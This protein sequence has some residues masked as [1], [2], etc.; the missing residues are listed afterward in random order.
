MTTQCYV[1]PLR[2]V[3]R[4]APTSHPHTTPLCSAPE[5]SILF[6]PPSLSFASSLPCS[7]SLRQ[8]V[9]PHNE[10]G[11]TS[12]SSSRQRHSGDT[13]TAAARRDSPSAGHHLPLHSP[14]SW[15]DNT[16]PCAFSLR[17]SLIL[18]H[19]LSSLNSSIGFDSL[20]LLLSRSL[21]SSD[22]GDHH[23]EAT[24]ATAE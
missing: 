1:L 10:V 19:T 4:A 16:Y 23:V 20:S 15:E 6:S 3:V 21:C 5:R 9:C 12:S 17:L 11:S 14:L 22:G 8:L 2:F 7:H 13:V 18:P 24:E